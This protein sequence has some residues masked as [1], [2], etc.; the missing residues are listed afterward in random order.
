MIW[1]WISDFPF[2]DI[3]VPQDPV[4]RQKSSVLL[5]SIAP[6]GAPCPRTV[7]L[8]PMQTTMVPQPALSARK[9]SVNWGLIVSVSC[10]SIRISHMLLVNEFPTIIFMIF[11]RILLCA[12][13][14]HR[15][16]CCVLQDCLSRGLL[17]SQW[18]RI[19]LEVMSRWNVQQC[20]RPQQGLW[21]Y[22]MPRRPLLSR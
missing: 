16:K 17:L 15:G 10:T 14:D 12:S 8:V 4:W 21:V 3:T 11:D 6:Q 7:Q 1:G 18:N 9:V 13:S 22:P 20:H 19:R 2:Q 5:P